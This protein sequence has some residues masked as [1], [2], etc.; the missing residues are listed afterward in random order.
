MLGDRGGLADPVDVP[1]ADPASKEIRRDRL[2]QRAD[3][4]TAV[5]ARPQ[6]NADRVVARTGDAELLRDDTDSAP[7]LR[8]GLPAVVQHERRRNEPRVEPG[9]GAG[10]I[11]HDHTPRVTG[12][13]RARAES[14]PPPCHTLVTISHKGRLARAVAAEVEAAARPRA[15]LQPPLEREM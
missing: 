12:V 14:V 5:P 2:E 3:L 7:R 15:G 6:E 1:G 10:H 8:D 4:V 9:R 11:A 13:C